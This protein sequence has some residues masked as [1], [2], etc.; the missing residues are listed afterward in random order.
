VQPVAPYSQSGSHTNVCEP[1]APQVTVFCVPGKQPASG[2]SCPVHAPHSLQTRPV[3]ASTTASLLASL[4]APPSEA[5]SC[6]APSFGAV[7]ASAVP[8]SPVASSVASTVTSARASTTAEASTPASNGTPPSGRTM[9]VLVCIPQMP[10]ACACCAPAFVHHDP[11]LPKNTSPPSKPASM[12]M[13]IEVS[14][15]VSGVGG[16]KLSKP[17]VVSIP[18][19][20]VPVSIPGIVESTPLGAS[21]PASL[22]NTS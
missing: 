2:E 8:A 19:S 17:T 20:C 10:H 16:T 4:S 14:V 7:A 1:H 6:V 21:W 3:F 9:H 15:P 12:P 5:P 13:G 18:A 22:P 11:G